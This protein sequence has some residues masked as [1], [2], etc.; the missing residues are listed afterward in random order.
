M[1]MPALLQT[2][3]SFSR[4]LEPFEYRQRARRRLK[5]ELVSRTYLVIA[6]P[7]AVHPNSSRVD[8]EMTTVSAAL[9]RVAESDKPGH[10]T[11]LRRTTVL[12]VV[13]V[14]VLLLPSENCV[15]IL[16][17]AMQQIGAQKKHDD[18][19]EEVVVVVVVPLEDS[20][21]ID[22]FFYRHLV[23]VVAI[24]ALEMGENM[25]VVVVV[26]VVLLLLLVL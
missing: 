17:P 6:V 8:P 7:L 14:V 10:D 19:E 12:G 26:V 25:V 18:D 24:L 21:P 20:V 22:L 2:S 13:V 5:L 15:T 16:L 1:M 11:C 3:L 4:K 23:E 9:T